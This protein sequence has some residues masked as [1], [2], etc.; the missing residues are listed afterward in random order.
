[1]VVGTTV[2]GVVLA[3]VRLSAWAKPA[4]VVSGTSYEDAALASVRSVVVGSARLRLWA[5]LVTALLRPLYA[6][7][8]WA[9]PP[10]MLAGMSGEGAT[11]ASVLSVGEA[12]ASHCGGGNYR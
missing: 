6:G 1:V 8:A 11:M 7:S 2:E 12:T 5:R 3:S 9:H 4:T 10:T